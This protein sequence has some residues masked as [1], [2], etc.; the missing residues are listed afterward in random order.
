[1]Y[2]EVLHLWIF[3]SG[4]LALVPELAYD[5]RVTVGLDQAPGSGEGSIVGVIPGSWSTDFEAGN[6][7]SVNDGVVVGWYIIPALLLLTV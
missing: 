1:M 5:S 6:S 4:A 7:F 2:L 3:L